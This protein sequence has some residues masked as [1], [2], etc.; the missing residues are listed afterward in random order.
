MIFGSAIPTVARSM[1]ERQVYPGIEQSYGQAGIPYDRSAL[2]RDFGGLLGVRDTLQGMSTQQDLPPVGIADPN[3]PRIPGGTYGAYVPPNMNW[4][5]LLQQMNQNGILSNRSLIP[6]ESAQLAQ[7]MA[8]R[9]YQGN[10]PVMPPSQSP[11]SVSQLPD[12]F[13]GGAYGPFSN[14]VGQ[15]AGELGQQQQ[16]PV[17]TGQ[18]R[19]RIY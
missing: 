5:D 4:R 14:L 7:A 1:M 15:V 17:K 2:P 8:G 6:G 9:P 19:G 3:P 16:R 18:Y 10:Q 13:A 12:G 11:I